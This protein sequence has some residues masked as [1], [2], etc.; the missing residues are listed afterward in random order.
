MTLITFTFFMTSSK[1]NRNFS[2]WISWLLVGEKQAKEN[3]VFAQTHA[4]TLII[5]VTV[6]CMISPLITPGP[7]SSASP[8]STRSHRGWGKMAGLCTS[9]YS[10]I[11]SWPSPL[12]R[13]PPHVHCHSSSADMHPCSEGAWCTYSGSLNLLMSCEQARSLR[14]SER[15]NVIYVLFK[16]KERE[17]F[18]VALCHICH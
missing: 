3:C 5:T 9:T 8:S 2:V 7:V 1:L 11:Q 18:S 10:L 12:C 13:S 16:A 17:S 4:V 6:C 14:K 15:N